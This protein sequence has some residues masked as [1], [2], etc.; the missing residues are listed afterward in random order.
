MHETRFNVPEYVMKRFQYLQ[1]RWSNEMLANRQKLS[2][3]SSSAFTEKSLD[4]SMMNWFIQSAD[5][6]FPKFK[7]ILVDE[8]DMEL[9]RHID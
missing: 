4:S 8:K 3:V 2:M 7:R 6:F 5:I 9:F 1:S